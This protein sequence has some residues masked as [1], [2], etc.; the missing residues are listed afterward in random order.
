[1]ESRP[2]YKGSSYNMQVSTFVDVCRYDD[3]GSNENNPSKWVTLS[4]LG[5][6]LEIE[7]DVKRVE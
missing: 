7:Q 4:A 5:R 1:M 2:T 3:N 6:E